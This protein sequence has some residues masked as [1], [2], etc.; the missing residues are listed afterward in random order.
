MSLRGA[1]DHGNWR[2]A[3]VVVTGFSEA[4]AL[5]SFLALCRRGMAALSESIELY[6]TQEP[7]TALCAVQLGLLRSSE[8]RTRILGPAGMSLFLAEN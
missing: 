3:I 1:L 8:S 2:G 6:C 5:S 7:Q 4:S